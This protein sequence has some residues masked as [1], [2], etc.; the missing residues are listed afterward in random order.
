MDPTQRESGRHDAQIGKLHGN[1]KWKH[2]SFGSKSSPT[3]LIH[4]RLKWTATLVITYN[5]QSNWH[6][7]FPYSYPAVGLQIMSDV[8]NIVL[9]QTEA[10]RGRSDFLFLLPSTVHAGLFEPWPWSLLSN[11]PGSTITTKDQ[12]TFKNRTKNKQHSLLT[13]KF[14][15][16]RTNH[17]AIFL[18]LATTERR[19]G[20]TVIKRYLQT[21]EHKTARR[22]F[23]GV[24]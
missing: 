3:A 11:W 14:C 8:G 19:S 16:K 7:H 18:K 4:L 10:L 15:G 5:S 13:Y 12:K 23:A 20:W 17:R 2:F 21:R 22:S 9:L 1:V 6:I 24:K